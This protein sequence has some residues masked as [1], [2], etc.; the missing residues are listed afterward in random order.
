MT[1]SGCLLS[2]SKAAIFS[3]CPWNT[4]FKLLPEKEFEGFEG[5]AKTI[6]RGP[7]HH[8]EWVRA[9]KGGAAP[10]SSFDIGGPLTEVIQLG[11]SAVLA[12]HPIE[13]DPLT[14]KIVNNAED[15]R[16]LHREYR[17]GWVL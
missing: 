9:C 16:L 3:D 12:G 15:N 14:G 8:A 13:Y 7:G 10:F 2:G 4:R 11:N 17:S 6:P 5:P 1:G